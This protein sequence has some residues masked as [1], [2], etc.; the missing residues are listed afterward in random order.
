MPNRD[1]MA[2]LPVKSLDSGK[3]RLSPILEPHERAALIPA[4]VE[5]ILNAFASFGGM[6]VLVVTGDARVAA[7]AESRGFHFLM[8]E[9]CVS[10]TAAIEA[11][12][13]KAGELGARGTMVVPGD[14]PLVQPED[15]A[16]VL[17]A[18]PEQGT[19]LVPAWDGRG[20]NAVLRTP[21]DLFPL[22]FGN[23]S[24]VPHRA[25]AEK[26][27]LPC[28]IL[29]N[30]R[31]GLDVDSP[32]DLRRLLAHPAT[33]LTHRVLASFDLEKRLR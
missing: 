10:E 1:T 33:T 23:D 30:E 31:L 9:T 28:T 24:F 17:E 12:T 15:L 29:Q 20:T 19:V 27:G 3:T 13:R 25:A 11:A 6:P 26:T 21:H 14:I 18:A 8:E 4:M 5:D 16:A 22:R 32:A 7:M 2:L